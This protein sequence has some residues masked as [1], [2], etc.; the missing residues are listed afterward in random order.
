MASASVGSS[1]TSGT[2]ILRVLRGHD[3]DKWLALAVVGI[4]CLTAAVYAPVLGYGVINYDDPEYVVENAAVRGGLQLST[5]LWALRSLEHMNW[6]PLTWL[7]HALDWQLFGP[8]WGGHHAT[9]LVLHIAT[10]LAVFLALRSLTGAPWRSLAVAALFAV[11]PI[12]VQSVAWLSERKN[13]L[14][15][16]FFA[17][18]LAAYASYARRPTAVRY[19][20][21]TA[22]FA[23]GLMAKPSLVT[24][25]MVLLLL[26]VWPLAR[27]PPLRRRVLLE[28]VPW[29]ALA[30]ASSI[31]TLRAQ[32]GAL[33]PLQ[34]SS[35]A[36][37]VC[38][39]L[40]GYL[41][42]L[43]KIFWPANFAVLY[44]KPSAP[45]WMLPVGAAAGL[46]FAV[47]ALAVLTARRRPY[48]LTGW[49]WFLGTLV[50]VS[51][52]V[53]VGLQLMAD[54]Y[55]YL[56]MLGLLLAVVWAAADA[57][58][59]RRGRAAAATVMV[60]LVAVLAWRTTI[61][62]GYWKDSLT[63]F[64]RAIALTDDNCVA[65]NNA[66][67]ELRRQKQIDAAGRYFER[68][69]A[70]CPRL[71]FPHANLAS[72]MLEAGQFDR[73]LPHLAAAAE[74][75][76]RSANAQY[77]LGVA[78]WYRGREAEAARWMQRALEADPRHVAA[79]DLLERIRGRSAPAP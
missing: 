9:S 46:L 24:T 35:V 77:N 31:V 70:T 26:D 57:I 6:H 43:E 42:Y 12:N 54:R 13:V 63:L 55:A 11:H 78:L 40:G 51:G 69:I 68:A 74:L 8:R 18:T 22:A 3:Q 16:L 39:A 59:G 79:R 66:A 48:L 32:A 5:V 33:E 60:A 14:S 53:Q 21:V 58:H 72:L 29:L 10:A 28:K 65:Y 64:S 23:L 20:A 62:L 15:G 71:D 67:L 75:N 19:A 47:T 25:P 4:V 36:S 38:S 7:S 44:P 37:R 27:I 73:A 49:L 56:P 41:G 30:A 17:L 50:P 1:P 76:P 61:T 2:T 34:D 45:C 52:L